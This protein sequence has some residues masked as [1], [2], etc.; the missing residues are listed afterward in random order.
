MAVNMIKMWKYLPQGK[1]AKF[2]TKIDDEVAD[3]LFEWAVKNKK[4]I[5]R[6]FEPKVYTNRELEGI[7][8]A[9]ECPKMLDDKL[10]E[11]NLKWLNEEQLLVLEKLS[12]KNEIKLKYIEQFINYYN[13]N[14]ISE[15]KEKNNIKD[16]DYYKILIIHIE[17][18]CKMEKKKSI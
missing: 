16:N 7:Y 5:F 13:E 8:T 1:M 2:M 14:N 9:L 18:L 4:G 12:L 6:S 17:T 15:E 3:R 10:L 11:M